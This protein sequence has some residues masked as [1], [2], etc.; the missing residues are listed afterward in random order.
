MSMIMLYKKRKR[1]FHKHEQS[2]RNMNG[3]SCLSEPLFWPGPLYRME[4]CQEQKT[5]A[6]P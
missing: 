2:S 1:A 6:K 3:H 5:E 4:D